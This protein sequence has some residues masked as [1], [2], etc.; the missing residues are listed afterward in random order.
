MRLICGP[1]TVY[2]K[3]FIRVHSTPAVSQTAWK[4]GGQLVLGKQGIA[5]FFLI[6]C[7]TRPFFRV[8][9]QK[10]KYTASRNILYL[11]SA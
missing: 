10:Y 2:Y 3:K 4:L 1:F 8:K 5:G 11:S 9:C 6:G 7:S